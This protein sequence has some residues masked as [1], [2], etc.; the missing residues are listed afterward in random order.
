MKT[1]RLLVILSISVKSP[2]LNKLL[3]IKEDGKFSTN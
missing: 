2:F 1:K 3:L